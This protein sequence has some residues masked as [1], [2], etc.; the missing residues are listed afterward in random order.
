MTKEIQNP[1]VSSA[2]QE[3]YNTVGRIR[4][5]L[6]EVVVPVVLVGNVEEKRAA[7]VRRGSFALDATPVGPGGLIRFTLQCP[8]SV[9]IRITD[10]FACSEG[11]IDQLHA[12]WDAAVGLGGALVPPVYMDGRLRETGQNPALEVR[13]QEIAVA[14]TNPQW[15]MAISN[16]K[17]WGPIDVVLGAGS[18]G[19]TA[20]VDRM[21]FWNEVVDVR[22]L[23]SM[24]F[25][26]LTLI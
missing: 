25:E 21:E 11:A 9:L 26:E 7:V 19:P 22:V 17:R 3:E 4:P 6:D 18:G 1:R 10:I 12:R 20:G 5:V 24:H 8:R 13:S 23:V 16:G 15:T 2:L 14:P